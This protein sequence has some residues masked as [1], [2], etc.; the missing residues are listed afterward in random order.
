MFFLMSLPAFRAHMWMHVSKF[1]AKFKEFNGETTRD[2]NVTTKTN[3]WPIEHRLG[4]KIGGELSSR[5]LLRS[6]HRL[7]DF[8]MH[9]MGVS[10]FV[11]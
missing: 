7:R 5:P 4:R 10:E 1:R 6:G 9:C 3:Y 11:P 2:P 8:H